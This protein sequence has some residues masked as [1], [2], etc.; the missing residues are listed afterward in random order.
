V[1]EGAREQRQ[2]LGGMSSRTL[3]FSA[4]L[5]DETDLDTL[6]YELVSVVRKTIQPSHVSLWLRTATPVKA[7]PEDQP[8]I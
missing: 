1:T 6:N 3:L 7:K 2:E 4:S 5:R 8:T